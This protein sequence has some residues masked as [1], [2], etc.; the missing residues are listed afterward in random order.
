MWVRPS[1]R[2][3][4]ESP[5]VVFLLIAIYIISRE[6][7]HL[8][9]ADSSPVSNAR[10][11]VAAILLRNDVANVGTRARHSRYHRLVASQY[12]LEILL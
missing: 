12:S 3:D 1:L 7:P 5:G 10:K 4:P 6:R 11:L 9:E 2:P 8:L